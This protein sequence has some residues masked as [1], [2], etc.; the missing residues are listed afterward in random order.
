MFTVR[1]VLFAGLA[2]ILGCVANS[3]AIAAL[4][5]DAALLDLILSPGREFFSI[6]FAMAL[7]PI[8]A[9]LPGA[10]GWLAAFVAL[11]A[12]ATLSAKLVWGAGAPWTF[13]LFVNAIYAITAIIVYVLGR[14]N[15]AAP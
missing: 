2:G 6:L 8:F 14:R 7:I 10:V 9:R 4:V 1:N 13:V 3:L 11:N 12:L 5:P 15:E